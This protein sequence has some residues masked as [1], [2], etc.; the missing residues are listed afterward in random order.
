MLNSFRHSGAEG[1]GGFSPEKFKAPSADQKKD[2]PVQPPSPEKSAP[3]SKLDF[4]YSPEERFRTA[5]LKR[6]TSEHARKNNEWLRQEFGAEAACIDEET[7]A[8]SMKAFKKN[9]K[10]EYDSATELAHYKEI[11]D[12]EKIWAGVSFRDTSADSIP[13]IAEAERNNFLEFRKRKMKRYGIKASLPEKEINSELLRNFR[14]ER[15][16][17]E[18]FQFEKVVPIVFSK[19]VGEKFLTTEA[20]VRDNYKEGVDTVMLDKESGEIV[21]TLDEVRGVLRKSADGSEARSDREKQKSFRTHRDNTQ[22]GRELAYG[23]S[24]VTDKTTKKR[25]LYKGP[26]K[27]L[28]ILYVGVLG[29]DLE[30]VMQAMFKRDGRSITIPSVDG[31]ESITTAELDLFDEMLKSLTEQALNLATLPT[32]ERSRSRE[33]F[34]AVQERANKLIASFKRMAEERLRKFPSRKPKV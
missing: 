18:S 4:L 21:C 25:S 19:V 32:G 31:K 16:L 10:G 9:Y 1:S 30:N 3:R 2:R 12:L 28:P 33:R 15:E 5:E 17:Q 8:L 6:V 13:E 24:I 29:Q 23:L 22:G 27:D 14:E 20:A 11:L 7:G 34:L 26:V